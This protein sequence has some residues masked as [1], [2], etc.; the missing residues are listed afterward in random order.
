M[1]WTATEP[2]PTA[3]ATRLTDSCRTSPAT[4]MP[5]T[6]VSSRNGARSSGHPS[7]W[8]S[9][10]SGPVQH[11]AALVALDDAV[12]PVGV[13]RGA[14][15]DEEVAAVH[16]GPLP[17]RLVFEHESFEV[18]L[19]LARRDFGVEQHVDP[20]VRLDPLDEVMAHLR[21]EVVAA[22]EHH[23]APRVLGEVHRR[24]PGRVAR[25]D[26]VDHLVLAAEGFGHRRAVVDAA[27]GEALR[28]GGGELAPRHARR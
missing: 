14:D 5:G 4:K 19:A 16:L 25:A 13:R 7:R 18:V 6:F 26:D 24:L 12:E 10:R 21:A 15:E 22:N 2:S 9:A 11:E 27:P 1:K 23:D 20:L 17:G 8:C 28:P 3:L